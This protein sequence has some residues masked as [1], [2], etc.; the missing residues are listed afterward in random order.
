MQR[1]KIP[2]T[3][4]EYF[5]ARWDFAHERTALQDQWLRRVGIFYACV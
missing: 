5:L 1:V 3:Q 2:D 4:W